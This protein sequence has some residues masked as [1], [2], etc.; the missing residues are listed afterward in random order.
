M[1]PHSFSWARINSP[2]NIRDFNHMPILDFRFHSG[3]LM[4]SVLTALF[5]FKFEGASVSTSF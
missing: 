5:E 2:V 1:T 3:K 4:S